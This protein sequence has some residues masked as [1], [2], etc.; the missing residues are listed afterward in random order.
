MDSPRISILSTAHDSFLAMRLEAILRES[1]EHKFDVQCHYEE[2]NPEICIDNASLTSQER[3]DVLIATFEHVPAFSE[4]RQLVLSAARVAIPL[5]LACPVVKGSEVVALFDLGADEVLPSPFDPARTVG[6]ILRLAKGA[7]DEPG[8]SGPSIDDMKRDRGLQRFVGRSR[9]LMC[10]IERIPAIAARDENVLIL[11]E[12]GTG[13]E[14]CARTIHELSRRRKGEFVG[15]TCACSAELIENE[16]F[17]HDSGAFTGANGSREGLVAAA[18]GGTLFLDDVD[19]LPLTAQA[20]LLRF[21]QERQFRALGSQK[22]RYANVRILATTN[23]NLEAAAGAGA[24]RKDLLYRLAVHHITLPPLRARVHDILLIAEHFLLLDE[25]EPLN[26]SLPKRLSHSARQK[27]LRH[28]WPGNV[29]ELQ[30]VMLRAKVDARSEIIQ[31]TDV[32][33][34]LFGVAAEGFGTYRVMKARAIREFEQRYLADLLRVCDGNRT[35]AAKLAGQER[36]AFYRLLEKQ[37]YLRVASASV[38]NTT[39]G[40]R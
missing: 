18:E 38:R 1:P 11:G 15:I 28:P 22:A 29:R 10:A 7:G 4:A 9:A 3:P 14:I 30:N 35:R 40:S 32:V 2:R 23:T 20:K 16:L 13:K 26:G 17:G 6:R 37:Q 27:L 5:A 36:R 8:C 12:T 34:S 39:A 25:N 21:L 31:A 33:L 19:L 24:F